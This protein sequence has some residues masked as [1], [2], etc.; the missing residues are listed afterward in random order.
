M[1]LYT[2]AL[3]MRASL[4]PE[5]RTLFPT[6]ERTHLKGEKQP[7]GAWRSRS[8]NIGFCLAFFPRPERRR[9]HDMYDVLNV[10]GQCLH[11]NCIYSSAAPATAFLSSWRTDLT[12]ESHALLPATGH[13]S[14]AQLPP[15]TYAY[16]YKCWL[17]PL[18]CSKVV[19]VGNIPMLGNRIPY[20]I[21]APASFYLF[22]FLVY[23]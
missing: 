16:M 3:H 13:P 17:R 7:D 9:R 11:S 14:S 5:F 15:Y 8:R 12:Q 2:E 4:A 18:F 23:F 1:L 22:F 19:P 6:L 20:S 21:R 10:D